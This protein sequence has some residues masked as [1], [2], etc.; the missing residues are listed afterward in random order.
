MHSPET[1]FWAAS[2]LSDC[3]DTARS[4]H[5][6]SPYPT[7]IHPDASVALHLSHSARPAFFGAGGLFLHQRWRFWKNQFF[8][9]YSI[10]PSNGLLAPPLTI[11]TNVSHY[12]DVHGSVLT[13]HSHYIQMLSSQN[14]IPPT[15][16]IM[17]FP[18]KFPS[19]H[20]LGNP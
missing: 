1:F 19:H 18:Y 15:P 11:S 3:P 16:P 4:G 12:H 17:A 7:S 8:S 9:L 14:P 13:R 5:C 2:S 20:H 6:I 10:M